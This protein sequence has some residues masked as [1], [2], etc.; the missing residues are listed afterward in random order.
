MFTDT[1]GAGAGGG[2]FG[3]GI[4]PT[5]GGTEDPFGGGNG[6]FGGGGGSGFL[7]TLGNL[8]QLGMGLMGMMGGNPMGLIGAIRGGYGL[9]QQLGNLGGFNTGGAYSAP[10]A[11]PNRGGMGL[12]NLMG[13][14]NMTGMAGQSPYLSSLLTQGGGGGNITEGPGSTQQQPTVP[15]LYTPFLGNAFGN[16]KNAPLP[17][18][19]EVR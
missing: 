18:T 11:N 4:D 17:G 7:G 3:A 12:S 9:A 15:P 8:G 13:G 5:A 2:G 19:F 10:G 14:T 16:F 6:P 1:F